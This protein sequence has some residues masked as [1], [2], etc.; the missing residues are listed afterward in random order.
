MLR[1]RNSAGPLGLPLLRFQA[2]LNKIAIDSPICPLQLGAR[3][4]SCVAHR[5]RPDR[6][7]ST[8]SSH[9]GEVPTISFDF[10][11]T[12]AN[13]EEADET[14]PDTILAMILTCSQT[15][16]ISCVPLRSKNQLDVMNRAG[17]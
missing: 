2:K 5:A 17:K 14:T 16:F 7:V 13:G 12:K 9:A 3:C 1:D 11:Y 4:P 8:G 10:F 15:G 6:H